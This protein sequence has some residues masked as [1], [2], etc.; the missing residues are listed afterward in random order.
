MTWSTDPEANKGHWA[1][2]GVL[3][4]RPLEDP[5]IAHLKQAK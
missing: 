1:M 2:V 3:N 4:P 5:T